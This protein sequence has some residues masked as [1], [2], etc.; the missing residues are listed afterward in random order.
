VTNVLLICTDDQPFRGTMDRMQATRAWFGDGG[1]RFDQYFVG[2]PWCGSTR[3]TMYSGQY[4]HTTG[5]WANTTGDWT[6]ANSWQR[7]LAAAGY[8]LGIGGKYLNTG[9]PSLPSA[10]Y[11]EDQEHVPFDDPNDTRLL[12]TWAAEF[13]AN[14]DPRPW[15]LVLTPFSPH[16]PWTTEPLVSESLGDWT[17]PVSFGDACL[18]KHS[19]VRAEQISDPLVHAAARNGQVK[20]CEALDEMMAAVRTQ[21]IASG[22]QGNTLAIFTSDNGYMWGEHSLTAKGYPY[23]E[24]VEVPF[25]MSWPGVIDQGKADH[26]LASSVDIAATIYDALNITPDYT[27]EG[28]SLLGDQK[29]EWALVTAL[30][31]GDSSWRSYRTR[32]RLY[33][34]W[35]NGFVEDYNLTTDPNERAASNVAAPVISALLEAQ[36]APP[37]AKGYWSPRGHFL[38]A[39]YRR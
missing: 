10:P 5:I 12:A 25:Y 20:E 3:V 39:V 32:D 9:S 15:V 4:A 1:T 21:L 6:A 27:V 33:V 34:L 37:S 28:L 11:F 24:S 19:S 36:T 22:D 23:R 13:I 31:G 18:D 14:P 2:T 30:A 8:R 29:R 17:A 16:E 7:I 26:R 35:G 38:N